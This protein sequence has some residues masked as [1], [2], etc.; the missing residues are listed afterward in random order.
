MNTPSDTPRMQRIVENIAIA[1]SADNREQSI[2]HREEAEREIEQ[3]EREL[4]Q[5]RQE[6]D[7]W[8]KCAK[9]YYEDRGEDALFNADQTYRKLLT[10]GTQ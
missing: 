9:H 6:R 5:M 2:S 8:K 4:N 10:K 7:E 1:I 3:L